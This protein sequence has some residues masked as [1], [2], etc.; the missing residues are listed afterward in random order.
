MK[1]TNAS[2]FCYSSIENINCHSIQAARK[3]MKIILNALW[4]FIIIHNFLRQQFRLEHMA[5]MQHLM[6]IYLF[7]VSIN[8]MLILQLKIF[9]SVNL[10]FHFDFL[11]KIIYY[12]FLST[13]RRGSHVKS[14]KTHTQSS[15]Y[16]P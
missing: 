3:N 12:D 16:T 15:R 2:F 6:H 8:R 10:C 13:P 5:R 7:D 4:T 14:G 9:L 1:R 11:C